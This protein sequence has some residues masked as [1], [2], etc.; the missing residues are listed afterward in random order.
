MNK[1]KPLLITCILLIMIIILVLF[2][3]N[4]INYKNAVSTTDN[5]IEILINNSL[6]IQ[7]GNSK[8]DLKSVFTSEF[9]DRIEENENNFYKKKLAP[10]KI[11][12]KNFKIKKVGEN[13]FVVS[14]H[15]DDMN[16]RY[17]QV[18]HLIKNE[19]V[20]LISDIEYDI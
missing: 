3:T 4:I 8:I 10:Y 15:I 14:V 5:P 7:Y 2:S 17:I 1:K 9:I 16:G 13:E 19:D 11:L 12:Y 20:Y 18:I 6:S